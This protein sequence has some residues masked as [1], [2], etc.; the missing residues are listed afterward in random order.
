MHEY[1]NESNTSSLSLYLHI[2][3]SNERDKDFDPY[4]ADHCM[5]FKE[6]QDLNRSTK[7]DDTE[8][9]KL[10]LEYKSDHEYRVCRLFFDAHKNDQWYAID[11]LIIFHLTLFSH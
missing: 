7:K 4:T 11:E 3:F 1:I 10:F 9:Y 2:S 8:I 6:F 5:S